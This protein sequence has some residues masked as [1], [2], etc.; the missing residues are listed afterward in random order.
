MSTGFSDREEALFYQTGKAVCRQ[1]RAVQEP[2]ALLPVVRQAYAGFDRAYS[3]A[4]APAR[5]MVACRAGCG[6]C[7]YERVGVQAHEVLIAAEHIRTHFSPAEQAAVTARATV[8]RAAYDRRARWEPGTPPTPCVLLCAGSCSI[9]P[10]RPE[11]CRAHHS[12]SAEAC[13]RNLDAGEEVV[14]VY[15]RGLR[16]RMFAVMLGIDHAVVEA[17]F[18]GHAYDFG[19]ALQAALTDS[20]CVVRWQQRQ[21][22]F[23]FSCREDPDAADADAGEMRP[24]GFFD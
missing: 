13:Q 8:H 17:G 22:A 14:D 21:P 4:P 16:G 3:S 19:S 24:V 10:A 12:H 2:D 6:T 20:L 23:P 15:I 5:R 7:C 18:D 9:Y 1:L 11:A